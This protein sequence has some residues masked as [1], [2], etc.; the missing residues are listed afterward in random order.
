M[1]ILLFEVLLVNDPS[2]LKNPAKTLILE[3][4]LV[5]FW[6]SGFIGGV[7][8]S[9]TTSIFLVLFWRFLITSL[10][11]LPFVI[12]AIACASMQSLSRQALIGAL[13]MFGY[14]ATVLGAIDYGVPAG[15][16]AL[17]AALQPLATAALAGAFLNER[18]LNRQ[19]LGLMV[20]FLGVAI[21][22]SSGL[23]TAPLWAYGLAVVSMACLVVATLIAKARPT[24]LSLLPSLWI[25]TATATVLFLP[26]AQ[27]DGR[28]QPENTANFAYAVLWFILLSTLGG[29]GLYWLC[30][31]RTSATRVS[32]LIYLTPPIT[33]VWA[34][35]MF[36]EPL[37]LG[38]CIGFLVCLAGIKLAD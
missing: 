1:I 37:S 11:L 21:A 29:Y 25:Q 8:A 36:G 38:A 18:V 22:V 12:P 3:V 35:V 9:E 7:L 16:A 5:I 6:S 10:V 13:A 15:T 17:I 23:G 14:L 19:W 4:G 32:S 28:L 26:L 2:E 27:L 31:A 30:L 20:G 33:S 34:L 24:R